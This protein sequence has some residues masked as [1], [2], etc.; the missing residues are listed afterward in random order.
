MHGSITGFNQLFQQQK[1]A[2]GGER[3]GNRFSVFI[4][5]SHSADLCAQPVTAAFLSFFS[6]WFLCKDVTLIQ[7]KLT[8]MHKIIHWVNFKEKATICIDLFK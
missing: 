8:H 6:L 2:Y 4:L 5:Q 1:E 7:Y 3:G